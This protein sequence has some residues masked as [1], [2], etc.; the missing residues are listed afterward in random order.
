MMLL[1]LSGVKV[2]ALQGWWTRQIFLCLNDQNQRTLMKCRNGSTSIKKAKKTNRELHA[3]RCD[4]KLKLSVARKMREEDEFYYPHNLDFR[5]RAYP[6]HPHLSHL[7]SDLCRGV[8]EYAEGRP[9][10]KYGLF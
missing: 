3:E 6:M 1:R 4:T 2:E 5:G 7:G 9:L 8:L 10:G